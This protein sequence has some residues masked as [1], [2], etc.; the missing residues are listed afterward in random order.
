MSDL[1]KLFREILH[2]EQY[3]NE[4]LK[5]GIVTGNI[6]LIIGWDENGNVHDW[7]TLE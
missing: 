2:A 6:Q 5:K 7:A 3:L 1:E 4:E